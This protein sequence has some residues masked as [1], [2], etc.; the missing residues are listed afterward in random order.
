MG[1]KRL[2]EEGH[3]GLAQP[4]AVQGAQGLRANPLDILSELLES[5]TLCPVELVLDVKCVL[6]V[7][8]ITATGTCLPCA[9]CLTWNNE[10][11]LHKNF[12]IS[13]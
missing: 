10:V 11:N 7:I 9:K 13:D 6:G 2:L 3:R 1:R 4:D 12:C 8:C 5:G